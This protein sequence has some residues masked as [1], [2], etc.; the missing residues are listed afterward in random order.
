MPPDFKALLLEET[1]KVHE[2]FPTRFERFFITGTQHTVL[3]SMAGAGVTYTTDVDGIN[4]E[5]W[6]GKMLDRDPE[7]TDHLQAGD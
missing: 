6:L 1:D 2:A 3:L 7:W 4:V 5:K